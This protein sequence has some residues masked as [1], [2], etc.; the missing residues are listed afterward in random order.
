MEYLGMEFKNYE[1]LRTWNKAG[2]IEEYKAL[3]ARFNKAPSMELSSAM[4]D[5]ADVLVKQYE[6][7]WEEIE[8]MEV[9]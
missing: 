5:L 1:E 6:M 9:A 7:R 8:E 3:A 4:S 2:K